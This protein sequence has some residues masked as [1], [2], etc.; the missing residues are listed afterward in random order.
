MFQ[1]ILTALIGLAVF[2]AVLI[3]SAN[4]FCIGVVIVIFIALSEIFRANK[5]DCVT[6]VISVFSS[7]LLMLGIKFGGTDV[8]LVLSMIAYMTASVFLHGK[9]SF[10]K[11]YTVAFS[12]YFVTLFFGSMAKLRM[13]FGAPE[14]LLVFIFSWITDTGAYFA[15]KAFG[16]HKLIEKVSPKKTV[17]GA[18]GGVVLTLVC[19]VGYL[20]LLKNFFAIETLGGMEYTG[21]AVLAVFA[22]VLSQLGDLAASVIKRECEIKDFGNLLPGHGGIMDRFDSV[23]FIAPLV[24]Y[25]FLYINKFIG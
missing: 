14:V 17:E 13:D 18:I 6:S 8:F 7:L 20:A 19:S 23:A 11:I 15:G 1:R 22:S 4:V 16:K 12:T 9:I 24:L 2:F 25:Y 21:I 5:A 10:K 3:P